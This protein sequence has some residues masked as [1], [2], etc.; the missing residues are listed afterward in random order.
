MIRFIQRPILKTFGSKWSLAKHYPAPKFARVIEPF[1]RGACYSL[2]YAKPGMQFIWNDID[3]EIMECWKWL[4]DNPRYARDIADIPVGT[5]REGLDLRMH[6][7]WDAANWVRLWQRLGRN[8]C[9]TVSKWNNKPGMWQQS[10]KDTTIE[11]ISW[12]K[13]NT[14]VDLQ[15]GE[16]FNLPD[17]EATW[18]IDPPYQH[19][20]GSVYPFGD[21][22]YAMLAKWCQLLPGQVIVCEQEGADWL[23]FRKFRDVNAGCA[24]H[25][26]KTMTEV[27]W[28]KG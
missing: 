1:A 8:D 19:Q 2:W 3:P 18:F 24:H 17:V 11:A 20:P 10:V 26:K 28:T 5:L 6:M 4:L 14:V 7:S 25:A 12:L 21:V 23:P 15:C 22:D 9:W 16:Y 27:I 13:E